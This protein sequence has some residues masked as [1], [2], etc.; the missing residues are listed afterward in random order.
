[1]TLAGKENKKMA[2]SQVRDGRQS[3]AFLLEIGEAVTTSISAGSIV[4]ITAKGTGSAFGDI[5]EMAPFVAVKETTLMDGDA[6]VSVTPLFLGQA[7]G[8][9]VSASKNTNDVTIDYDG[10]TNMISDGI[11]TTSGSISGSNITEA[12]GTNS[13]IN[14]LKSRF[15]SLTEIDADGTITHKAAETTEKDILL[16]IWNGRNAKTGDIL[17]M[18]F[19]PALFSSLSKGGEYGS[20]QSFDV[21]FSGNYSDEMGYTGGLYQIPNIEGFMPSIVRPTA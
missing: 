2:Y 21:D 20:P 19:I 18:E 13:A 6:C 11:V 10:A 1:M 15:G 5:P 16:I 17:E 8:K 3:L 9:S 14:L 12:V 4:Y 7:T